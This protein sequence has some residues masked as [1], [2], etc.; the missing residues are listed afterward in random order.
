[1]D[2][3]WGG[4]K[5]SAFLRAMDYGF[6]SVFR[7]PRLIYNGL[8]YQWRKYKISKDTNYNLEDSFVVSKEKIEIFKENFHIQLVDHYIV[9]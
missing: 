9:Q 3:S 5:I 2:I 7:S 4:A 8:T 6:L 1:L